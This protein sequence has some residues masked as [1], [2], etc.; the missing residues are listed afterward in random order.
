[1]SS[2]YVGRIMGL[3]K[4]WSINKINCMVYKYNEANGLNIK[5]DYIS[6]DYISSVQSTHAEQKINK[7]VDK[8]NQTCMICKSVIGSDSV[9]KKK[10]TDGHSVTLLCFSYNFFNLFYD[11]RNDIKLHHH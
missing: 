2:R 6:F 9:H 3:K 1:M 11:Y 8:S 5:Y 10:K 7:K 4:V